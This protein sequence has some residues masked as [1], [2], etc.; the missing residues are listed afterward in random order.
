VQIEAANNVLM[1]EV[2]NMD[3]GDGEYNQQLGEN[4]A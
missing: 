1:L 3:S 4:R 2:S